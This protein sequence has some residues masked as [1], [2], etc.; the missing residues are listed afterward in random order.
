MRRGTKKHRAELHH[1]DGPA[2]RERLEKSGGREREPER[3]GTEQCLLLFP[4]ARKRKTVGERTMMEG[5]PEVKRRAQQSYKRQVRPH[6]V[7]LRE[8]DQEF[9]RY[10][11][12]STGHGK[13]IEKWPSPAPGT[14][15]EGKRREARRAREGATNTTE[16]RAFW[17]VGEK[18][19]RR[20]RCV[21]HEAKVLG[22][23]KT[24]RLFPPGPIY[25]LRTKLPKQLFHWGTTIQVGH[26]Y[27]TG[28]IPWRPVWQ[29]GKE[30]PPSGCAES[31][32]EHVCAWSISWDGV[33]MEHFLGLGVCVCVKGTR[34]NPG[35]YRHKT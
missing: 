4:R 5:R 24:C 15:G 34:W 27:I 19:K 1:Q 25:Q 11:S 23:M 17:E 18:K 2:E 31:V 9:E 28:F 35:T 3:D 16:C 26:Y 20:R 10:W 6:R 30:I 13:R 7:P 29:E 14:G 22:N 21:W 8:E 12:L 33:C 32:T